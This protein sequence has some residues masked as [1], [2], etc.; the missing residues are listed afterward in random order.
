MVRQA[1]PSMS[2]RH[3]AERRGSADG[4]ETAGEGLRGVGGTAGPGEGA[5]PGVGAGDRSGITKDILAW[6]ETNPLLALG[7]MKHL[8][9]PTLD[10]MRSL[11]EQGSC[12]GAI[13]GW[14][15]RW[16]LR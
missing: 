12:A 4:E 8:P 11:R 16:G 6:E 9:L 3:R 13:G 1:S 2:P 5:E 7:G 15:G 10:Q 14:V